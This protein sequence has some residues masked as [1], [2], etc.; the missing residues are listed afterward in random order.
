MPYYI[1][2]SA[3]GCSGWATIKKDGSVLGCHKTKQAAINQMVALSTKEGIEPGGERNYHDGKSAGPSKPAPKKDQIKGS[4]KNPKGSASGSGNKIKLSD[5]TETTLKNKA[6]EHNEKMR[7]RNRPDWTR[8]RLG[9]L[10]AAYRRGAGAYSTS[11]RPGISRSA[12]AFAR[13]NAFLFLARTGRPKRKAYVQDNDL[14]HPDHPRR[15]KRDVRAVTVPE[16]VQQSAKRGLKLYREGKGGKG[17]TEG[18]LREARA[19]AR[20]QMSDD[21][22]I[23]ANAWAARHKVDLQRP[24]NN[25]PD[26]REWPGPGAVAHYLWGID[27]LDPEPA[28]KWFSSQAEKIKGERAQM[29]TVEVRQVQVQDL[30][31]R[32]EGN[33]RSF[34]GYAAVFNSDSE[35]LPFIEQIRPGA[36]ERT[37][38]SRNQIKMFVNHEDTMVLASTRAGTLRL[39]EDS[40]GLRVD[41]D[42]PDTT[43][44]KDL[45]VLMKRGDVDSMSFG[46]H[47]PSGT[48]EWSTDG[49]RRYLNEIALREVSIVTGFPA[50]EATSATIRKA[51]LLAQRT[52][53]DAELLAEA[54]TALEA[55]DILDNDQASLL[56]QVVERQSE[57]DDVEAEEPDETVGLLRD[58]LDLIAKTF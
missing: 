35:P 40:Q 2:D 21:K 34:S 56:K 37:L 47:V 5:R 23:R 33:G 45:A 20:G 46:F 18:T 6:D 27:P 43:Y 17:L 32:E 30:E 29:S 55:G 13:V 52:E 31:L 53:T 16:Y 57:Q 26:N 11:H 22:V 10:K 48:D 9:A 19:M 41:A 58:K 1:S 3:Y 44:A 15:T 4:K 51:T 7:E 24:K 12:W 49:Q 42:L 54:L 8:V 28:R 38:S 36:F 25:D 39:K 50:Y 14:L